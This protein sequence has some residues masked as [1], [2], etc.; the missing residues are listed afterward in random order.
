M[1]DLTGFALLLVGLGL[2]AWLL[3]QVVLPFLLLYC[4]GFVIFLV[5]AA[6]LL[7]RGRLHPQ[8]LDSLL[9]PG[10][11]LGITAIALAAPLAHAAIFL[12]HTDSDWWPV[13]LGLN[14]LP[15]V[16][17]TAHLLR[18]HRRQK[19]R[20]V[21]EGHDVED[22]LDGLKSRDTALEV[23]A[24]ALQ[25]VSAVTP[26]LEPWEVV[27]GI[28]PEQVN[29]RPAVFSE[30]LSR[31]ED[32]RDSYRPIGAR[33]DALLARVR[34]GG[35]PQRAEVDTARAE[36]AGL[37]TTFEELLRLSQS[38]LDEGAPGRLT[39]WEDARGRGG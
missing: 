4:A 31:I 3:F 36:L 39:H 22:L 23:R 16:A 5:A 1:R 10:V 8:H 14:L 34:G 19:V 12:L 15:P 20:Y 28:V 11:A 24:D 2:L 26:E 33:L 6:T 7:W 32:L 9:R 37:D 27:A 29:R 21:S 35:P 13:V 18:M 17:W 38:L 25:S 30:V